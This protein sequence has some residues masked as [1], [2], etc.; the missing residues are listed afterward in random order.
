MNVAIGTCAWS[1]EDWRGVFYPEHLPQSRRLEFYARH[2]GAVEVDATFYH[3]P[4]PQIAAHWHEVTPADFLFTC[5]LP[6]AI[7]HERRL[8]ESTEAV[9]AFL[10]AIVPMRPK[11]A[12]I[13]IQL[14]PSFSVKHDEGALRDF[15]HALPRGWPFAIEFRRRDWHLP[16]I[17]H[18]LTEHGVAWVWSDMTPLARQAEGALEFAPETADFAYVRLMGDLETKYRADGSK[19]H[20]YRS[21]MWPRDS[22][23]DNWAARIRECS[24]RLRR[25]VVLVSNHFEGF[26]PATC[27][28]LAGRLGKSM[29]Q[30]SV[31]E[32]REGGSDT[33]Q[34]RLL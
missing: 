11:L 2:L 12:A 8:R 24:T 33:R 9:H 26:A 1:Y 14:P 19:R 27:E 6:R 28:R 10:D 31:S 15:L 29:A 34:M 32:S 13:L 21:L 30:R 4:T 5:K 7:T 18:L 17:A 3:T 23:L 16:R 25:V 22:S 20:T